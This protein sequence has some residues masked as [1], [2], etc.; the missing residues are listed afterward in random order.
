MRNFGVDTTRLIDAASLLTFDPESSLTV[1]PGAFNQA[2][3]E[4]LGESLL[5]TRADGVPVYG[6]TARL[7]TPDFQFDINPSQRTAPYVKLQMS[8][9]AY[10]E[11]NLSLH[12]A[13]SLH[14]A[15]RR[16]ESDLRDSGITW[17]L[18]EA[19]MWNVAVT[20]QYDVEEPQ[21]HYMA[22]LSALNGR[23]TT[24]KSDWGETGISFGNTQR[25]QVAYDKREEM[26]EHGKDFE[27]C[28]TSLLRMEATLLNRAALRAAL[29]VE[30]IPDLCCYFDR[31]PAAYFTEMQRD[32]FT[33]RN[34]PVECNCLDWGAL[35]RIAKETSR[36]V[37]SLWKVA[38]PLAM[39][40]Q[41]GLRG[42][43]T[44]ICEEF[45]GRDNRDI[46]G[47]LI[48]ELR[49]ASTQLGLEKVAP[50]GSPLKKLYVEL[51]QKTL[52]PVALAA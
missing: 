13:D 6:V 35:M 47:A 16:A 21:S 41:C 27:R 15:M 2:T 1:T 48:R 19:S 18:A 32:I 30:T 33:P 37:A 50:S 40:T 45:A 42:A 36:P 26:K 39:V 20:R 7:N 28:P 29:G 34:E 46:R 52:A 12:N 10:A 43:E 49:A 22:A 38:G 23:K 25:K 14:D 44:L 5:F 9:A 17:K 8:A 24:R 11:D 3:G 51:K 31:L 4:V